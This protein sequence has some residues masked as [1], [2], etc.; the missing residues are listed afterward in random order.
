MTDVIKS[1]DNL[2]RRNKDMGDSTHAEQRFSVGGYK[3]TSGNF[4]LQEG[5]FGASYSIDYRQGMMDGS[6]DGGSNL[7]SNGYI[8]S[9]LAISKDPIHTLRAINLP[10]TSGV[11][12]SFV[13]DDPQDGPGGTGI[14]Y[15]LVEH[16][17]AD[18]TREYEIVTMNG[19]TPVPSAVTDTYFINSMICYPPA[20]NTGGDAVGQITASNGGVNYGIILPGTESQRS[21]YRMV[22]KGKKFILH[23]LVFGAISGTAST[24]ALFSLEVRRPDFGFF[25]STSF[26]G[27]QDDTIVIQIPGTAPYTAGT[28]FGAEVTTDKG[29]MVSASIFGHLE[30]A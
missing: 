8:S 11:Q 1:E 2:R 29:A 30:N 12:M 17:R 18:Y 21:A 28:I 7:I 6:I 16:I 19:V 26:A 13:S 15:I 20:G 9:A 4:Q 27:V 3:D 10:A 22:P 24:E 25:V 5:K 23:A 14:R